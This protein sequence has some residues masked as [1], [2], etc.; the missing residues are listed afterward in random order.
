VLGLGYYPLHWEAYLLWMSH[1]PVSPVWGYSMHS[2]IIGQLGHCTMMINFIHDLLLGRCSGWC[3]SMT[4]NTPWHAHLVTLHP[5][6]TIHHLRSCPSPT[7][8]TLH[9]KIH[10]A[11]RQTTEDRFAN[12]TLLQI[13]LTGLSS[14]VDDFPPPDPKAFQHMHSQAIA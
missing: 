12:P 7:G 4:E 14:V 13:P 9:R 2:R 11:F 6:E 10:Q 3:T 8:V 5:S 1:N